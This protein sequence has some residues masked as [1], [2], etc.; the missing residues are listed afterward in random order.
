MS[1]TTTAQARWLR[2]LWASIP[3]G[4]LGERELDEAIIEAS[5]RHEGDYAWASAIRATL[6]SARAVS[7]RPGRGPREFVYERAEAFPESHGDTGPGSPSYNDQLRR[8]H[9]EWE[10]E[11]RDQDKRSAQALLESPFGRQRREIIALVDQ[12]VDER[13]EELLRSWDSVGRMRDRLNAAYGRSK[14]EDE[15]DDGRL[16]G[17]EE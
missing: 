15:A 11:M 9:E 8:Q 1:A 10:R 14:T 3:S 7:V 17:D 5:G 4:P 13:V 16:E 6:T 2:R 12:R